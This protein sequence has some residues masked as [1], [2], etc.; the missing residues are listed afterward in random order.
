[1]E[2]CERSMETG[3]DVEKCERSMDTASETQEIVA[4]RFIYHKF[5]LF[6]K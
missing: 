5:L 3:G 2:K 6:D 1:M 4:S